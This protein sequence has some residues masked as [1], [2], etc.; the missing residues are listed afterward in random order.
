MPP[1]SLAL[2]FLVALSLSLGSNSAWAQKD[3]TCDRQVRE[4]SKVILKTPIEESSGKVCL[5]DGDSFGIGNG[6]VRLRG[7]DAPE[8]AKGCL[9]HFD[10]IPPE[11]ASSR[12]AIQALLVLSEL[13][14]GGAICE[15]RRKGHLN[16]WPADC[17]IRGGRS[18][19]L[20]MIVRGYA[21]AT[22]ASPNAYKAA[23]FEARKNKVGLWSDGWAEARSGFPSA[24]CKLATSRYVGHTKYLERKARRAVKLQ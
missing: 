8:I 7:I 5:D 1:Q 10:A 17:S 6:W 14:E 24:Q 22:N 16:R 19:A 18:L 12:G 15:S 11:C 2:C 20:E 4:S 21:C 23:D 13:L 3:N 9:K